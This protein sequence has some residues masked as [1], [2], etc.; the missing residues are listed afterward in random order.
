MASVV[1]GK[2][3]NWTMTAHHTSAL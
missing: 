2:I 3:K 1:A